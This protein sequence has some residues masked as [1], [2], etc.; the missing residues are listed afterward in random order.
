[1]LTALLIGISGAIAVL[2]VIPRAYGGAAMT[3]ETGSMTP[4]LPVG[5]VVVDRPVDPGTLQVGDIATY[6][7]AAGVN[8]YITHRITEVH[9]DTNPVSFTFK[10][11]ANRGADVDPVPAGAIRGKVWFDVPY[12]GAIR[13]SLHAGGLRTIGLAILIIAL[14]GYSALQITR[15]VRPHNRKRGE[16]VDLNL[17]FDA[18]AFSDIDPLTVATLLG[19]TCGGIDDGDAAPDGDSP[20]ARGLRFA[21]RG[22]PEMLNAVRTVLDRYEPTEVTGP[23]KSRATV[24]E[25][26]GPADAPAAKHGQDVK[27]DA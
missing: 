25:N 16:I 15:A 23:V 27:V 11:D 26:P 5:S 4:T 20:P 19:G 10:G 21:F 22:S 7:K 24:G 2:I 8:M 9:T 3:V 13:D 18:D 17:R 14:G 6:Q 1:V 12:L